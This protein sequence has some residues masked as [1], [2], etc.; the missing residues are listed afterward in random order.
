M[1]GIILPLGPN[2]VNRYPKFWGA[3]APPPLPPLPP[4]SLERIQIH[5][6][7][8]LTSSLITPLK[9]S[10]YNLYRYLVYR[11]AI[12]LIVHQMP[13]TNPEY[14]SWWFFTKK[15]TQ[16]IDSGLVVGIWCLFLGIFITKRFHF[17]YLFIIFFWIYRSESWQQ[18]Q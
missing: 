16:F 6:Y 2:R 13:I 12:N 4:A 1:A 3:R 15:P 8:H 10:F 5:T 18:Y 9:S 7:G 17:K 14:K 11:E